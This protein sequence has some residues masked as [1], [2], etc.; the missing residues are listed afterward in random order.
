MKFEFSAYV[1]PLVAAAL[2]SGWVAFYSLR[3]REIHG[4][5]A[6]SILSVFI[7]EWAVTYAFELMAPD[8]AGK[9]FWG[10][11]EYI[12]IAMVAPAWLAFALRYTGV[13]Q[14]LTSRHLALLAVIPLCT[15][16]LAFTTELHGLIW[17]EMHVDQ[18][19]GFTALG[20]T[21]GPWFWVHI[22]YSYLLL[23]LG[24]GLILRS[25]WVKQGLYRSQAV[26]LAIAALTPL[27][28]NAVFL[29]G[30][31]PIPLLDLTPFTFTV[32]VAAISW[33]IF[34]LRLLD[35]SPIARDIVV[36]EI[37]D[38]VI[39]IDTQGRIADINPAALQL[40]GQPNGKV[41]GKPVAEV[42][43]PWQ[44][45]IDRFRDVVD[46]TEELSFGEGP[47]R[48]WYE[49]RLTPLHD[50]SKRLIG[51]AITIRNTTGPR[52]A[53]E[54]THSFL[55][56]IKA[57]QEIHLA[58]SEIT[59]LDTL[60]IKM[61]SL[62]QQ[63]LGFD[64][65]GL[66]LIDERTNEFQGTYGVDLD[67]KWRDERTYRESLDSPNWDWTHEVLAL[68]NHAKTW[69][70]AVIFDNGVVVG[71]GWK[72][73][74]ALWNGHKA[75]GY[76][77]TDNF[78]TKRA[79]RP[80][81][82]ELISL[83][84][85]TFGHLIERLRADLL[86]QESELR[87]RQIVENA[88]DVIYRTDE[89]GLFTFINPVGLHLV[90]Y[91]DEAEM[92][93][94]HYLEMITPDFRH[95]A[96]RFYDHQFVARQKNTYYEFTVLNAEGRETWLGQN[97]QLLEEN[98]KVIGFQALARDITALKEAQEALSL[99][100]DQAL[101]ASNMKSQLLAKVSHELR[102]PLGGVLGYA[103]LLFY[104][105]FGELNE[106]QRDA[107]SQVIDSAHYLNG[108][109]NELLDQAQIEAKSVTLNM[110][111]FNVR[112]LL[113]TVE[114]TMSVV[115]FKKEL[116]LSAELDP[117]LPE[118]MRGDQKRLLQILIN[119]VGNAIKFT[120]TGEVCMKIYRMD[121]VHWAMQV[122]D[123]GMG[124]PKEAQSFIFEPFRQVNSATTR[125]NR[126]TGLG[127]SISKQLVELM[128]GEIRVESEL[129]K[130][131]TFTVKLPIMKD[132]EKTA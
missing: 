4:A 45:M 80:Y 132:M 93:G 16:L 20:V 77:S 41:V 71:T 86:L 105:S 104:G 39:V 113:R 2:I 64:R 66:F 22:A 96:K 7:A 55:E 72:A 27:V 128:G 47:D 131:S 1:V 37:K 60:Y 42:L 33:G 129:D 95:R 117:D 57:L 81:E 78:A 12:G 14:R 127:L 124:I 62:S 115:A 103:E 91:Q 34:E 110:A 112:T 84:G 9:I 121:D 40:I 63:R 76:L 61:L 107:A 101:E 44:D 89:D 43:S 17:T 82:E 21:H 88:S 67:G 68:P 8:L 56:E 3:R 36:D 98:G 10:K 54:L 24:T 18:G 106:K 83:L 31:S 59:D 52:R 13:G 30:F 119:L 69:D 79:A 25:I 70:D 23:V 19:V 74:A 50:R 35:I 75:I 94:R 126:G 120:K 11:L 85:S 118:T 6:L 116:S 90:G 92:L 38:S 102:T 51:R 26:A 97:V 122:S 111:P 58:L 29:A 48:R 87:Y 32:T 130:G 15:I 109:V 53:E 49:L 108:M 73:G 5:L 28:G 46:A 125:D 65:M 123:T 100:R 99:A 114:A